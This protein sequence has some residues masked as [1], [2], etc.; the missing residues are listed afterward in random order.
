MSLD[1]IVDTSSMGPRQIVIIA[2]C[3]LVAM[4]DGFDTQSIALASP[5]IAAAWHV[6][7]SAFGLVFG[8][9]LFGGML[10]AFGFGVIADR[11]G[12]KPTLLFAVLIFSLMSLLTPFTS[13]VPEL[14]AIRIM[15]GIGLGGALPGI[16]SI[17]S[18]YAPSRLRATLV[19][20]MFCGFPVGAVI[21]GIIAAKLIPAFGWTSVFYAGGIAP[22]VLLPLILFFLLESPRYLAQRGDRERLAGVLR[23]MGWAPRW[24]GQMPPSIT[25]RRSSVAGL[26]A[27]GRAVGTLLIWATL[28]CALLLTYFLINW[29]PLLARQSGVSMQGAVLGVA[30]LNFGGLVGCLVVGRLA[31]RFGRARSIG[32][33][34]AIGAIAVGLL[35][36]TGQSGSLLMIGAFVAGFFSIGAQMCT[37]AL[38]ADYYDTSLRATGVGWSIGVS[39]IGAILGPVVGGVMIGSGLSAPLLF[40]VAGAVSLV[41][42]AAVLGLGRVSGRGAGTASPLVV[43]S[44]SSHTH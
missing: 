9:G 22:L 20:L 7:P 6:G 1:Q 4:I 35:G 19:A 15:T 30:A 44:A 26:F 12:R 18:E 34:F 11:M 5:G 28:F 17:T 31:D 33:A 36:R 27:E 16:I 14:I 13:S 3:S 42:G 38:C 40:A 41:A 23:K 32:I 21:G 37:V 29:I 24:N 39:R 25:G 10:G 43:N 2:I 8:A